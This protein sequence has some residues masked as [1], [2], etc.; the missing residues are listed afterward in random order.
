[1]TTTTHQRRNRGTAGYSLVEMM[2]TLGIASVGAM[3]VGSLMERTL[4]VQNLIEK[5]ISSENLRSWIFQSISCEETFKDM[6]RPIQ[7][8]AGIDLKTRTGHTFLKN[9]KKIG[10]KKVKVSCDN[11]GDQL[12]VTWGGETVLGGE[13]NPCFSVFQ[14]P[15]FKGILGGH[16]SEV[17]EFEEIEIKE[18]F[19][20]R[21]EDVFATY[22]YR[23]KGGTLKFSTRMTLGTRGKNHWSKL[24]VRVVEK[25][26]QKT[27]FPTVGG[28]QEFHM[29][30][31]L[32]TDDSRTISGTYQG[33]M[34]LKS[35][36]PLEIQYRY[37]TSE[38]LE[39]SGS[40]VTKV[41]SPIELSIE[42]YY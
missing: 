7:C 13:L 30:H 16:V 2:L 22:T 1:M 36:K 28:W 18:K 11:K 31:G 4:T 20:Q 27:I 42:D 26:S 38:F 15:T 29:V 9:G 3:A 6:P 5:K 10:E 23:P 8:D 32:T 39:S 19:G 25:K 40:P 24:F 35:T 34:R 37:K 17:L 41:Y 14:E 21:F 12:K 33:I